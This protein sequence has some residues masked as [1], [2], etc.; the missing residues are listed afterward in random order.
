M[1]E[2]NYDVK[3]IAL[4]QKDEVIS[5]KCELQENLQKAMKKA[6]KHILQVAKNF[7]RFRNLDFSGGHFL[8]CSPP[9]KETPKFVPPENPIPSYLPAFF[10]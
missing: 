6:A 2:L 3:P 7:V 10:F 5:F 9:H 8:E 4:N 1:Q